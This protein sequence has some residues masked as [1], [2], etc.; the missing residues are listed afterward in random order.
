MTQRQATTSFPAVFVD[1]WP[2]EGKIDITGLSV[3]YR[4]ELDFALRNLTLSIPAG[5]K[6]VKMRF[7]LYH[8]GVY[9]VPDKFT[10]ETQ[11]LPRCCYLLRSGTCP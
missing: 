2:T 4:V 1:E 3:K 6:V 7:Y 11:P 5:A 9:L 8:V 10:M